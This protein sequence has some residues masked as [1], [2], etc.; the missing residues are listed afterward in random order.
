MQQ[1][2]S[3]QHSVIAEHEHTRAAEATAGELEETPLVRSSVDLNHFEKFSSKHAPSIADGIWILLREKA[4]F[5]C[6]TDDNG[7]SKVSETSAAE[8]QQQ[9]LGVMPL[10]ENGSTILNAELLWGLG[11]LWNGHCP[12]SLLFATDSNGYSMQTMLQKVNGYNGPTII[13]VRP[14]L[15]LF[16]LRSLHSAALP[17]L[18][19]SF[20]CCASGPSILLSSHWSSLFVLLLCLSVG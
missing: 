17:L 18:F 13:L 19:S 5:F 11:L 16:L 12:M 4:R 15:P 7:K 2:L 14:S 3:S 9:V 20:L 10:L 6:S 1:L 8:L